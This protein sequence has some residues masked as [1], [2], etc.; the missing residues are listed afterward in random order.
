M[1]TWVKIFLLIF[2]SGEKNEQKGYKLYKYKYV[3]K[4]K[5]YLQQKIIISLFVRKCVNYIWNGLL[6]D[7]GMKIFL[8]FAYKF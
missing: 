6:I 2:N 1:A 4:I 7:F 3:R 8:Q 5:I